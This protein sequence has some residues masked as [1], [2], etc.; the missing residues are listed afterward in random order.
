M[1]NKNINIFY[2]GYYGYD[3]FGDEALLYSTRLI[4]DR[5]CSKY[6][7]DI[8]HVILDTYFHTGFLSIDRWKPIKVLN[9][10]KNADFIIFG[11]GGIFQDRTSSLSLYYYLGIVTMAKFL[12]KQ[13]VLLGQGLVSI[14]GV[15]NKYLCKKILTDIPMTVR[16]E[17]SYRFVFGFNKNC[18]MASDLLF[19][20]KYSIPEKCDHKKA[21]F[22]NV[23]RWEDNNEQK[24]IFQIASSIFKLDGRE[25][26]ALSLNRIDKKVLK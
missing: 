23:R 22:F 12:R 16:D 21:V 6:K 26:I 19:N 3:N 14:N 13:I 20:Y 4:I 10:I 7:I 11:G 24:N 15:F 2:I 9:A 8:E 25:V 5:V 18:V 17:V 1:S